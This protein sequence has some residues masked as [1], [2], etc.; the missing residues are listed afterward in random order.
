MEQLFLVKNLSKEFKSN[1][2]RIEVLKNI[3]MEVRKGELIGIFGKSGSGKST[4]MNILTGIDKPSSGEIW[5]NHNPIHSYEQAQLTKWRGNNIG[6]VFQ[7]FQLLSTLTL[8]ENIILPMELA[9]KYS[10]KERRDR[11]MELLTKL[12]IER[13]AAKYPSMVSGGE[14][15]RTAIARALAN[16]PDII[17]ADEPTGNLDS[18]MAHYVFDC[19]EKQVEAGKTVLMIT[20]DMSMYPR[21]MRSYTL[22]DGQIVQESSDFDQTVIQMNS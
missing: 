8:L 22:S 4:L 1:D 12:E 7:A 21:F 6:I 15:Q 13:L 9:N 14:Q 18:K 3:N 10:K 19:F 20:H 16:D 2:I 17:V 11:A 5:F